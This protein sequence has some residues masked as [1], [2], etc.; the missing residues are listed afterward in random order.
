MCSS[1]MGA[2]LEDTVIA[3]ADASI[4]GPL[5][6]S[7]KIDGPS[8][9]AGLIIRGDFLY[10][11]G[12]SSLWIYDISKATSPREL[13]RLDGIAAGRQIALSGNVACIAARSDGVYF[14]DISDPAKPSLLSRFDT[15]E[16]A[17]GIDAVGSLVFVAQRQYGIECID[18]SDPKK[19]RHLS[20]IRTPEAQSCVYDSGML[21]VGDWGMG[22]LTVLDM[23]NPRA[24]RQMA[25]CPL[26]GY[27]DGLAIRGKLCLASTGHHAKTGPEES[28]KNNGH[29]LNLIDIS[30]PQQPRRLSC[31]K[32]PPFFSRGNDFWTVRFSGNTAVAADS[33]N[34]VFLIDIAD[35][36]NPKGIG[37]LRLPEVPAPG[38]A[39]RPDAV[40]GI[41][42]ADGV[43]FF[44]G[45]SSGIF[46]AEIP[47][48]IRDPSVNRTAPSV[49][50]VSMKSIPSAFFS[51]ETGTQVRGAS[52][53]RDIAYIAASSGGIHIVRLSDKGIKALAVHKIPE[54]YDVKVSE[55]RLYSAEG[56]EGLAVYQILQDGSLNLLGRCKTS[57]I[58][59]M[60]WKPDNCRFAIVSG[61]AGNLYFFDISEPGRIK[62]VFKHRQLGILYGDMLCDKL[63]GGRYI[64]N[65]WHSGGLAWYDVKGDIPVLANT[66]V[67]RMNEHQDG[68][69]ALGDRLLMINR[70]SYV[71]LSANEPGPSK[72]WKRYSVGERISGIPTVDGSLVATSHRVTGDVRVYDFSR[73]EKAVIV[74][75]RRWNFSNPPGTVSFWHGKLLVPL[76]YYGVLLEKSIDKQ[77]KK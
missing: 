8:Q 60:I 37:Q 50:P 66:V 41:A 57:F 63:I 54:A 56:T 30:K 15:I 53:Y 25:Q 16:L 4:Y 27:G 48:L 10:A 23:S 58:A 2:P 39:S 49:P 68:M 62:E 65:N 36:L 55:G 64:A 22:V 76:A 19:P 51:Y 7:R 32:F 44:S 1:L 67:E 45:V 77:G 26:T 69:T 14:V 52:I 9:G 74:K 13:G 24:P 11:L 29:S 20:L 46:L 34:G 70:G 28:R 5:H 59:Q 6:V 33:H 75:E 40:S 47:G 72:D 17:T 18:I 3:A 73:P 43:L 71:L 35:P 31:F 38:G 61:R 42:V 12:S 21:Y